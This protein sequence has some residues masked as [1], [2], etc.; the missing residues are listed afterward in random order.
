MTWIPGKFRVKMGNDTGYTYSVSVSTIIDAVD[1]QKH[2][3]ESGQ[4]KRVVIKL[5]QRDVMKLEVSNE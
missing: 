5:G 4:W 2:K 1:I 3:L